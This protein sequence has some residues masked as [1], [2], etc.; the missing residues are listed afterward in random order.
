MIRSEKENP[1]ISNV[2]TIT[3]WVRSRIILENF[4]G[5]AQVPQRATPAFNIPNMNPVLTR[6]NLGAKKTGND[7]E[8]NN[9]PT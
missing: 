4:K 7:I 5:K 1:R 6:P 8:A 9:A 3:A 2:S